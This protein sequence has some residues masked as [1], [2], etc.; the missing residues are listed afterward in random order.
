ML[1]SQLASLGYLEDEINTKRIE[2][3][4][5]KNFDAAFAFIQEAVINNENLVV[6]GDVDADGLFSLYIAHGI[7]K[8]VIQPE[9]LFTYTNKTKI[10]GIT[11]DFIQFC[12]SKD[13]TRVLILDA[14]TN[15]IEYIQKCIE[16]GMKVMVL[17]H[18]P[19]SHTFEHPDFIL[20]NSST[21]EFGQNVSGAYVTNDILVQIYHKLTGQLIMDYYEVAA[22]SIVSDAC[23]KSDAFNRNIL[24]HFV[25]GS[26]RQN[27][28]I[29]LFRN[30]YSKNSVQFITSLTSALN[31]I[32]RLYGSRVAMHLVL[33]DLKLLEKLI[34]DMPRIKRVNAK[35]IEEI[36][37]NSKIYDMSNL[38]MVVVPNR[39]T[40]PDIEDSENILIRNYL[41]LVAIKVAQKHQKFCMVL[42]SKEVNFE[43]RSK[44]YQY[45]F[46]ARD[47]FNRDSIQLAKEVG[48]EAEGHENAWGGYLTT[49]F[50][51][52]LK[53]LNSA[54]LAAH[55]EEIKSNVIKVTDMESFIDEH[56]ADL[57]KFALW[58]SL[59]DDEHKIRFEFILNGVPR[60]ENSIKKFIQ[61][62]Y[63]FK[64]F[65]KGINVGDLVHMIF[66]FNGELDFFVQKCQF[67][68]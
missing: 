40:I 54:L 59:S 67:R 53:H 6:D 29:N 61:R 31:A 52:R 23:K 36:I 22:I 13:I 37:V 32:I 45:A 21:F 39:I 48:I 11:D 66:D 24:L 2:F 56:K 28:L 43:Q 33:R 17:D 27:E 4:Q 44:D 3:L 47:I 5:P 51:E 58:N 1:K 34:A 19:I 9:R 18:H 68:N 64:S 41:G 7:L 26:F 62:R 57:F 55:P 30:K 8:R 12:L 10:H 25:Q 14:G 50:A 38:V 42:A 49:G 63:I 60:L 16:L 35:V 46:S 15:D 65:D 20:V